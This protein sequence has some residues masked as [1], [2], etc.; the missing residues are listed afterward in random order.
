MIKVAGSYAKHHTHLNSL[1]PLVEDL[2]LTL[3]KNIL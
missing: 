2:I 1:K 3:N